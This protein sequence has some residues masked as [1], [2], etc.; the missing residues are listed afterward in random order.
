MKPELKV[1]AWQLQH[2]SGE[3]C[4]VTDDLSVAAEY[5]ELKELLVTLS[6]AQA[7]IAAQQAIID[8]LMLEYCPDEMTEEQLA[9]YAAA[10]KAV[11]VPKKEK[12]DEQPKQ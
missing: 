5:G 3:S 10:Q 9:E 1:A 11:I 2:T 8:E 7:A 12:N 4:G 6:D